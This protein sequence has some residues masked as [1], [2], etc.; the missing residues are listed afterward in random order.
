[1]IAPQ[2]YE[3]AKEDFE[4]FTQLV[5]LAYHYFEDMEGKGT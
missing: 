4:Y 5:D 3:A 2:Q 1:M